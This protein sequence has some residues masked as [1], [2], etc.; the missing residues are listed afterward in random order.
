MTRT[1]DAVVVGAGPGGSATAHLLTRRGLDVLLVDKFAFPRDKTCGD[2]LTPRA[3]RVLEKLG[4]L[5]ELRRFGQPIHGYDVFAPNGQ[6]TRAPL[7]ETQTALV[8]PRRQ[9][10]EVIRRRAV[11]SGAR[12]MSAVDVTRVEP[13]AD[14]VRLHTSGEPIDARLGILAIGASTKVL[15]RSG[16]LRRPPRAMLAVRAYYAGVRDPG[17]RF[18]LRFDHVP[19]PGYGWV[20][21]VAGGLLNVGVGFLPRWWHRLTARAAFDRFVASPPMQAR[22]AGAQLAGPVRGYPIRVDFLQARTYGPRTLL[23]GEAAGLV[24]PLTGEGIDYALESAEIAA[25]HAA[26][27]LAAD[28]TSLERIRGYDRALRDRFERLF[29][30]CVQVRD[31]YCLPPLLDLLVA[32]ANRRP[33]LRRL[34]TEVVLGERQPSSHGPIRTSARLLLALATRTTS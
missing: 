25:E 29:R 32:S 21:P 33:E 9:L 34:L 31:W 26:S 3:L 28:D 10:D 16:I 27:L 22:L 8:V 17:D 2:G 24:N 4:L 20:F 1:L 14:G 19:L 15:L 5:D 23:V 7:S 12:F 13:T 11:D 30:F 6:A 18:A